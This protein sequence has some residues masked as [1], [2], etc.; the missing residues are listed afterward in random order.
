M[1]GGRQRAAALAALVVLGACGLDGPPITPDPVA[2]G[3]PDDG[4]I[5][6]GAIGTTPGP[7]APTT[8]PPPLTDPS[9]V[10][11]SREEATAAQADRETGGVSISGS[12]SVG[13]L[14]RR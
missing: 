6:P 3:Q 2:A 9:V 8:A 4:V 1:N 13:V 10:P 11:P 5:T 7:G 14:V 12:G